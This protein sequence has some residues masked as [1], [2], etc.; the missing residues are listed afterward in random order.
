M[1]RKTSWTR[2]A[3]QLAGETPA[4]CLLDAAGGMQVRLH[5]GARL[6]YS[7]QDVQNAA[8]TLETRAK[9]SAA[10]PDRAPQAPHAA[11]ET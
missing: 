8:R 2:I 9:R 11:P 5:D 7:R 4:S 1:S 3:E 6:S 10:K